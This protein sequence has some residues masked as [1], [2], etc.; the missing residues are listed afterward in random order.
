MV[1]LNSYRARIAYIARKG[2]A[3]GMI[4]SVLSGCVTTPMPLAKDELEKIASED[5]QTIAEQGA[6]IQGPISMAEAVARALKYN[7]GHRTRLLEEAVAEGQL[8][9]DKWELL[10]DFVANASGE[11]R[12]RDRSTFNADRTSSSSTAEKNSRTAD[13]G[14]SWNVLDFGISYYTAK[15]NANRFL[16]AQERRRKTLNQ[17]IQEVRTIY[18]RAVALQTLKGRIGQTIT[19]AE[20]ALKD[21]D[22]VAADNLRAPIE[23]LRFKRSLLDAIVQLERVENELA[24]AKVELAA[25]INVTPGTA[26]EIVIP[27]EVNLSVPSWQISLDKMEE[28]ALVNNPD[29]RE[30]SYEKRVVIDES[31]KALIGLFPGVTLLANRQHDANSFLVNNDWYQISAR[32]SWNIL[33]LASA[34]DRLRQG[35]RNERLAHSRRVALTMA[36]LAQLHVSYAEYLNA[37]K[38]FDRADAIHA[39]DDG[40]AQITRLRQQE[41]LLSVS[42]LVVAETSAV[43]AAARRYQSYAQAEARLARMYSTLGADIVEEVYLNDDLPELT[44]IVEQSFSRLKSGELPLFQGNN[45]AGAKEAGEHEQGG[46]LLLLPVRSEAGSGEQTKDP[47][48]SAG[49]HPLSRLNEVPVNSAQHLEPNPVIQVAPSNPV[50]GALFPELIF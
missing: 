13:I 36:I 19:L 34:P 3:F 15:Q 23:T 42:E 39:V 50:P 24:T 12:T 16:A 2:I 8:N 32:L 44:G 18:W 35:E 30:G 45:E 40:I 21:V 9:L 46:A 5:R 49:L 48:G 25:L 27:E 43:V 29:I 37:R 26:F 33:D 20:G 28:I 1:M 17:I 11:N 4:A 6:P 7:L 31:K 10:P 14:F 38:D 41:N 22:K 47:A